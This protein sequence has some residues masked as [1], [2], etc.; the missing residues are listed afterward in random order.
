V[1]GRYRD[2]A[3]SYEVVVYGHG[4]CDR[5]RFEQLVQLAGA[6]TSARTA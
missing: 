3:R 4:A 2:F 6:L 5:E 1:L